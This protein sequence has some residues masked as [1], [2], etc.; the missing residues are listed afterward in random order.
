[1]LNEIDWYRVSQKTFL[2]STIK[3]F[4][5]LKKPL[6]LDTAQQN[7]HFSRNFLWDKG[8]FFGT[9]DNKI[10]HHK[11]NTSRGP[12]YGTQ[13]CFIGTPNNMGF[14]D[15][16]NVFMGL[17]NVYRDTRYLAIFKTKTIFQ[18]RRKY[19]NSKN[20]HCF[21]S[22][23]KISATVSEQKMEFEFEFPYSL[24]LST[25]WMRLRTVIGD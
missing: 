2:C 10:Q 22:K 15:K 21:L 9:P 5:T 3:N 8:T 18:L 11:T 6:D 24:R 17:W 7:K 12:F 1:M 13:E 4:L 16:W 23:R 19:G 25:W 20:V 14:F